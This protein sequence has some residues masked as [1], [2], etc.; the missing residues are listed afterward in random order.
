MKST[1]GS[2][3]ATPLQGQVVLVPSIRNW[4]SFV[5]EPNAEIVVTVP[6]DGDVQ[7]PRLGFQLGALVDGRDSPGRAGDDQ[8]REGAGHRDQDGGARSHHPD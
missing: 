3:R 1:P 5:P 8:R 4:F 2:D 7:R 6:L